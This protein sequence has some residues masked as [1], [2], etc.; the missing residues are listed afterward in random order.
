MNITRQQQ[1]LSHIKRI[2]STELSQIDHEL[3]HAVVVTDVL[4][5][6]DGHECRIWVDAPDD[7][8]T[9]LN[10][11]HHRE[12]QHAFLKKFARKIVPKLQFLKDDGR[13]TKLESLLDQQKDKS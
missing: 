1:I 10:G 12:I 7:I 8:V 13:V 2:V 3:F 5:S 9:K 4:L 11:E 6:N